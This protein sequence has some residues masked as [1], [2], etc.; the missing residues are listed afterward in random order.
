MGVSAANEILA[1]RQAIE[2]HNYRYYVLDAPSITDAEY[3]QL[4]QALKKLEA[5]HPELITPDSPTQR[6]GGAAL[7]MFGEV[8]HGVPMLSLDNAFTEEDIEDFDQRIRDRLHTHDTIEYTCEPKLDGLAINLHYEH[9]RLVQAA[10]R[11]DGSTGEDVTENIRTIGMVPLHLRGTHFPTVL[12]VRGEVFMSKKGFAQLNQ[13]AEQKGDKTFANPRNA[14]AG[15]LRQLDSKITATRP[16]EI[17][18]YGIGLVEG[19]SGKDTHM[20]WLNQLKEWGLRVSPLIEVAKGPK[21]CLAYYERINHQREKLPY[22]IDGVVYKVND[23]ALQKELGFVSK[24]PRWA[25]AHKFPAE[26]VYTVIEAVEF[27]VGRT[28]AITPVARLKPVYVHGVTVSNATLHN[29]DEVKRKDIHIGDTVIVR[30]AGD[31]IPE[32]VGV[33]AERRSR[34]AKKIHLPKRCPV[35]QSEI[36]LIPGEAIARCTGG[37]VC[38]AQQKEAIKHFSSRRAM[39]IEGLGDKLSDQLVEAGL[40]ASVADIYTLNKHELMSLPRMGEKS[41]QNLLDEIDKSRHT[42]FPRFLYALGIREVGE[43]TAKALAIHFKTLEALQAATFET[44]QHVPDVGPVVAEHIVHFFH[45][46]HNRAAIA[47]LLKAKV[48]WDA[49]PDTGHQ[50]LFGQTFVLTGTLT[51]LTRDEAKAKLEALG[52]KVA[53]SVSAKTHCVVAGAEAGSKLAKA[54][55]LGVK[56]MDEDALLTLLKNS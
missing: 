36:E 24:A 39:D 5:A 34:D 17:Y 11:G 8:K 54:E 43:A 26:E 42:T 2:D 15:S 9:G 47:K 37:L 4:Y 55:A 33:I 18:C 22:E 46:A 53:G 38:S 48:H 14:A 50:P 51:T 27:Q 41:A 10:T 13:A 7:K 30:R 29:M 28:G 45:E 19:F 3:D 56:V 31:V 12:D 44:L 49:M 1:L 20:A 23:L 40:L 16:L 32:V 21:A 35:C 6:V 52:A 25:I